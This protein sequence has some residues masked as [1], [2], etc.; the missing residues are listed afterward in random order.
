M[1]NTQ[2]NQFITSTDF[3]NLLNDSRASGDV[4]IP[5][6]FSIPAGLTATAE[7]DFDSGQIGALSRG[8][9]ASTKN[10]TNWYVGQIIAFQRIGTQSG[11]PAPYTIYA[12]FYRTSPTVLRAQ[13]L[14]QN[15]YASTLTGEAGDETI[16][17]YS[18]QFIAPYT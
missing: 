14:I 3:P 15:V 12:L 18:N 13:V 6:G 16:Y 8:R 1:D 11:I 5:S 17:F 10:F 9:I 4:F 7:I 2:P